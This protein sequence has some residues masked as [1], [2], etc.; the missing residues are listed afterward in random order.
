MNNEQLE[1]FRTHGWVLL[2]SLIGESWIEAARPGLFELY[3]EPAAFHQGLDAESAERFRMAGSSSGP[4]RAFRD[5]Q[6]VGLKEFPFPRV[7]LS[8]LAVHEEI[9]EVAKQVLAHEDIR[10]YQ[11]E[12]FAKYTGVTNYDQAWHVD[13][14]N[15]TM[16]PPDRERGYFQVQMFLYLSDV[17]DDLGATRI[18]SREVTGHLSLMDLAFPEGSRP[19]I[20]DEDHDL[21]ERHAVSAAA[22]RG[23]LLVYSSDVVHRGTDMTRPGGSRFFF[24]L[25]WKRAGMD[26]I[27]GNP[28]P[29]KGVR[30]WTPLVECLTPA[31]LQ[32]LGFPPPGHPYWM[33]RTLRN[34][35]IRYP[36]L[37]LTPWYTQLEK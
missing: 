25:A 9:I 2:P 31:Q 35:A 10:L 24:N 30:N 20:S 22:P 11:A 4:E 15:H 27:G 12:T 3:P 7:E 33:S 6:F 13:Y 32:V 1:H 37:D 34:T 26:W 14:T 36:N 8:R 28:W 19:S 16:L 5:A 23:S 29:R 17:T 18:V 21:L